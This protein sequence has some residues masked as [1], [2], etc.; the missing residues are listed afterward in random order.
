MVFT[1][2]PHASIFRNPPVWKANMVRSAVIGCPTGNHAKLRT[3]NADRLERWAKKLRAKRSS[4]INQGVEPTAPANFDK[5]LIRS[6]RAAST[7][8]SGRY[9]SGSFV[10]FL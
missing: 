1:N 5:L 10:L 7:A 8:S 6:L 3:S 4:S 2:C 9:Q